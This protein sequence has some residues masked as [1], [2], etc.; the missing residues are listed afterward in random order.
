MCQYSKRCIPALIIFL[1]YGLANAQCPDDGNIT[2]NGHCFKVSWDE[3]PVPLPTSIVY[4]N[5]LFSYYTGAGT[6]SSPATYKNG[7]GGVC[8]QPGND[9]TGTIIIDGETCNYSGGELP[10][11]LISFRVK[12]L[13]D[14]NHIEWVTASE[15][16]NAGF[17]IEYLST[18]RAWEKLAWVASDGN[19]I[20][21]RSYIAID[22]TPVGERQYYRLVQ[23]DLDGLMTIS[24]TVSVHRHIDVETQEI[25]P[26]PVIN[27]IQLKH[28]CIGEISIYSATGILIMELYCHQSND[29]D[30]SNLEGGMYYVVSK[31]G[32]FEPIPFI[33]L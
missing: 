10:V 24:P 22:S 7:G 13:K 25:F 27:T 19:Q 18:E 21:S 3:V 30:L 31:A 26:N 29:Y 2:S 32:E 9:F 1:L 16:N 8:N 4:N 11:V 6:A 20:G 14:A 23:M 28:D 5:T 12:A 17:Y 33:K 15:Y